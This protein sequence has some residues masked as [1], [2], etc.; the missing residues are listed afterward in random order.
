MIGTSST[1][2]GLTTGCMA[3]G[4]MRSMFCINWL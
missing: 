1:L 4:G 2:I 3:P